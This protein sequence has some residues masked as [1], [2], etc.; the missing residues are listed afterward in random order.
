V[1]GISINMSDL[2][3]PDLVQR[4]HDRGLGFYVWTVDDP[5]DGQRLLDAGVDGITTNRPRWFAQQLG[6]S[7]D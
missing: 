1:A 5:A 2:I 4:V 3:T 6:L 7:N